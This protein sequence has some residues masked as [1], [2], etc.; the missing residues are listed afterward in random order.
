MVSIVVSV[1]HLKELDY[2]KCL[3]GQTI[4][5]TRRAVPLI[6]KKALPVKEGLLKNIK[7][8]GLFSWL[9]LFDADH[10]IAFFPLAALA[11]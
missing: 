4:H 2:E 10:A 11:K 8:Q 6:H 5:S 9:G 1:E 7:P 3:H